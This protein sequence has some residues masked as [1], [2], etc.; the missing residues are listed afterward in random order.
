[1]TVWYVKRPTLLI[2]KQ[3]TQI[4]LSISIFTGNSIR[5]ALCGSERF[6]YRAIMPA[7]PIQIDQQWRAI[8]VV[9]KI[10][11]VIFVIKSILIEHHKLQVVPGFVTAA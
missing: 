4:S 1:M 8:T 9:H 10:Q 3:H 2:S 5:P 6:H 7:H 11:F